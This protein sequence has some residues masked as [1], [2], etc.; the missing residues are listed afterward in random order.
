MS[1][2]L[3]IARGRAA[4]LLDLGDLHET[5]RGAGLERLRPDVRFSGGPSGG[6]GRSRESVFRILNASKAQNAVLGQAKY[7]ARCRT[8]KPNSKAY[9]QE[10][11][12][13]ADGLPEEIPLENE[14]G[15]RV[16][17]A[18]AIKAELRDWNLTPDRFNRSTAYKK[19]SP[20]ERAVMPQ[21]KALGKQQTIHVIFSAPAGSASAEQMTRAMRAGMAEAF[22]GH[23]YL[24]AVHTDHG[25][26]HVHAVVKLVG[27]A[28]M[29][30]H[31]PA[32]RL[33]RSKA[34]L[35]GYREILTKHAQAAGIDVV[36][37]RR[38]DRAQERGQIL[39]G[40]TPLRAHETMQ[41]RQAAGQAKGQ[42]Q[43]MKS[44]LL[45]QKAPGWYDRHGLVYERARAGIMTGEERKGL[46]SLLKV[47]SQPLAKQNP[48]LGKL[49]DRFVHY[50][51]PERAA[52]S[53]L[54]LAQEN[55]RLAKW[56][57]HRHPDAF[58]L[59]DPAQGPGTMDWSEVR[60]ALARIKQQRD[61]PLSKDELRERDDL[62]RKN[63]TAGADRRKAADRT[64]IVREHNAV[65][66]TLDG[67]TAQDQDAAKGVRAH[68][69]ATEAGK[70]LPRAS[71]TEARMRLMQQHMA[72]Q[73]GKDKGLGL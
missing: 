25:R 21:E 11:E 70:V 17:G 41:R 22:G 40:E 19:A 38:M 30:L 8:D 2:R 53:F 66:A 51:E 36:A 12:R 13:A 15:E 44:N 69:Q 57:F 3:K 56:A 68:V 63:A 35:Q 7:M 5:R 58:G 60:G 20:E 65:A 18:D 33:D 50:A 32:K 72:A 52:R 43:T 29:R 42:G 37:T 34:A 1:D 54:A 49:V 16:A 28:P 47:L 67:G 26:P 9:A 48:D 59:Y 73:L 31:E 24:W 45:A 4:V 39:A 23:R 64:A 55:P 14:R 71:Q 10:V 62:A 6:K 46:R 61:K 27:E